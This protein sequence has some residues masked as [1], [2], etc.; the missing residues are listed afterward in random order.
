VLNWDFSSIWDEH[1]ERD[2][3]SGC[4]DLAIWRFDDFG[5]A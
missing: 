1:D 4:D 3:A 5:D 2:E